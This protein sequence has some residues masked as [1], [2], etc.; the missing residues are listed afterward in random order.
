MHRRPVLA[1]VAAGAAS[2]AGCTGL[3]RS[4][5][6]RTTESTYD[7]PPDTPLAV[8][9]DNGSV[10]LEPSDGDTLEVTAD[11]AG[12]SEE[13]IAAVSVV[14]VE[15]DGALLLTKQVEQAASS[16]SVAVGLTV[17]YPRG[18]PLARVE[19]DNGSL[20]VAV[21]AIT[22]DAR[23]RTDNGSLDVALDPGL[24]ATVEATTD[25][26]SVTVEGFDF[27][28]DETDGT[29]SGTLGDGS[30]RLSIR[31]DNGSLQLTAF[32]D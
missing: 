8:A 12:P 9:L 5:E 24:D 10:R 18:L 21:T 28:V 15:N 30:K 13:A 6:S 22:D 1:G 2:L 32:S 26:G 20:D 11:I 23:L 19:T 14:A 25:N 7:V 31:T 27:R 16:A 29:V 4:R 17:R 3:L